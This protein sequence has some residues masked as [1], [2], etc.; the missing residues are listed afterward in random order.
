MSTSV[1]VR[2]APAGTPAAPSARIAAI[3]SSVAVQARTAASTSALC[4]PRPAIVA[5][6]GSSSMSSRPMTL[7]IRSHCRSLPQ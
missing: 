5:N 7:V 2:T 3:L 4:S 6:L 1:V